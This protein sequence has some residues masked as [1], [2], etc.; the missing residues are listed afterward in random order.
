[1]F[2]GR[3]W[4]LAAL[5]QSCLVIQSPWSLGQNTSALSDQ[6]FHLQRRGAP[7]DYRDSE[8]REEV[9]GTFNNSFRCFRI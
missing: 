8:M 3:F 6:T 9:K 4:N 1:M 5:L 7:Q 2:E